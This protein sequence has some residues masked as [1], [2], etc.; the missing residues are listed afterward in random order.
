MKILFIHS[1]MFHHHTWQRAVEC[2]AELGIELVL[3]HQAL[4]L[5]LFSNS[6]GGGVDLLIAEASPGMPGF[7]EL[8]AR[9]REIH[10]R[11]GLSPEMPADFTTFSD[12]TAAEFKY[13][14]ARVC[15]EN[16]V[17][18]ICFLAGRAG[19]TY[20]CVP[21]VPV[22]T[23]GIYHPRA[24]QTFDTVDAYEI[25]VQ[26]KRGCYGA[27]CTGEVCRILHDPALA[28]PHH[29]LATYKYI[30]D[31]SDAVVH[32]GAEGALEYLPGKQ[33]GLSGTCFPEISIGDLPNLYVYVLDATGDGITA[34][35]RGQAVLVDHLT[36]VYRP[37][38]LDDATQQ[39]EA[40]L[41]QFRKADTLGET[42]RREAI[43]RELAPLLV[44]C[45]LAETMPDGDA[46]LE[47]V[48]LARRRIQ[49]I[50]QSLMPEGLHLLG[51]PPDTTGTARLL[52]TILRT[53]PSG[54][55][56][57]Q[58][59]AAW[60]A[61]GEVK[62]PGAS[63]D[64]RAT[65]LLAQLLEEAPVPVPEDRLKSLTGFCRT[66]ARRLAR[67]DAEIRHLL[68][69]LNG[70]FIPPGLSGA[71]SRGNLN[72]LPTGRNFFAT[73][74]TT[75][76]TRAAWEMGRQMANKLLGKYWNEEGAFP[77][78]V[79]IS[80]WSSDAFKSDGEL[81]CQILALMGACPVW[82][83]QGR[84]RET[85]PMEPADLVLEMPDGGHL[86][87]PRVDVVIQTSSLMRDLVPNF[88][89]LLDRTVVM[90]SRLDESDEINNIRKHAREQMAQLREQTREVLSEAQMRRMATLR[91]FS[92]APGTYGLGVGLALDASAWQDPKDLAEVYINW[93]GHAY[94]AD[95]GDGI[96]AYGQKARQML[97]DQLA[98]VDVTYMKQ[99]SAEY[100]VLDCGCYAV[101]QGGMAAA[102][103]AVSGRA[104]K[105][106]W[107][108][109]TAPGQTDI[110]DLAEAI[111]QSARAKLLNPAWIE[112]M[113]GHGYQGA[114]A[115]ASR[116]NNLFKWSAT[117]GQVPKQLFDAVVQTYILNEDNHN[118]MRAENSYA[119]E[120]I[121]RRLLEAASRELWD[122]DQDM[123]A[124]VQHAALEIEGDMEETMGDVQ[125]AFQGGKV[126]V[127]TAGDVEKWKM[128]W[129][130]GALI[131]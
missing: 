121:T 72:V 101:S 93:G 39:A 22:C 40:L 8:L 18:G 59:L 28:P 12:E 91:V 71:V 74:V 127:L 50:K 119:L 126:E 54:L 109:T 16:Y 34:K 1:L 69:G 10:T 36:P 21:P 125:E 102:T 7:E 118:W 6:D 57:A 52:A 49:K 131:R 76:P 85:E 114:Q 64:E 17:N 44:R 58:T 20:T 68:Q 47:A 116:V 14:V 63:E 92:A 61:D 128:D 32:F 105:L 120:E 87:R 108:D 55:P 11:L 56:D 51:V 106:Y 9:G 27:K 26:P 75:L 46:L 81:L 113:R 62:E 15:L 78:S 67:C 5:E 103:A 80:I 97:A 79:G 107:G 115:A 2:L 60:S 53:P 130:M 112:H 33:A 124:A 3:G 94:T 13:Y 96:M 123:L 24:G 86:P 41:E 77:D 90:L 42:G 88:C 117:S 66:L 111:R 45:G 84:V 43:G 99:S 95:D 73:D 82:D 25:M 29:W 70:R 104:P 110:D 37:A 98:R 48:T 65:S 83:D 100:D 30:Q 89:E 122:A 4:V 31:H 23:S 129:R 35:R 19:G 38:P